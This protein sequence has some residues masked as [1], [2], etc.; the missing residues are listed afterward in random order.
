MLASLDMSTSLACLGALERPPFT[1]ST[2]HLIVF[3]ISGLAALTCVLVHYEAMSWTSRLLPRMRL[4]RRARIVGLILVM[5]TALVVEVWIFG[6]L[7]WFLS[8]WPELGHFVGPLGNDGL[9]FVYYSVTVFTTLGFG[10][11]VPE[12]PLR[13]LTGTEALVGLSLIT[14]SASISFLEMQRDWAEFRRPR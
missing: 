11:I 5:L 14:W 4:P 3:G 6:L 7:Y 12:G 8:G 2:A 10:D 1:V 13:I 9:D